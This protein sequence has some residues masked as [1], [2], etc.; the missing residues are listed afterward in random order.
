[1]TPLRA[2][3][4][5]SRAVGVCGALLWAVAFQTPLAV[6]A[7]PQPGDVFREYTWLPEMAGSDSDF[8][9][10]GGRLGY[11][12]NGDHIPPNQHRDG[13]LPFGHALD[14]ERATRAEVVLER[15]ESHD[16]THGLTLYINGHD[17]LP[18][19]DPAG[20]PGVAA[21]YMYHDYPVVDVPLEQLYGGQGNT[22]KLAVDSTQRWG[23]P[24]NLFYGV[25]LRVYYAPA[26]ASLSA[27]IAGLSSGAVVEAQ[28]ALSLET[29]APQDVAHVDY[30][31]LFDDV[32][33][34]GDGVY[35]QWQY[36]YHKG[37]LR[38]HIGTA[39]GAPF[40]VTWET[41]W[42]PDQPAP[43]QVA[44]RVTDR[45]GL[46]HLT[47]AVERL[48]LDRNYHVE[49]AR[50]YRQPANWS[51]REDS[52][53]A[54]AALHGDPS[55]AEAVQIVWRSWSPC[56]ARGV[57][58]NGTPVYDRRDEPC[59]DYAEHRLEIDDPDFLRH[60]ENTI[61]T[62]MTPYYDGKMVHGMEVQWPGVMMKVRYRAGARETSEA[63]RIERGTYAARPHFLVHTP[64][65]VYYYD[66]ASGGLSRLIDA[67]GNDWIA[68]WPDPWDT[69]PASAASAYRGVPNLVFGSD[70]GG[71]GHPGHN[72][73]RT[74]RVGDAALRFTSASEQWQ[75]TWHFSVDHARL[76]VER[77]D[78]D[79]AYWFLYEGTPGGVWAPA[80]YY[81]GTDEAGPHTD[82]PDF[83]TGDKRFGTWQW[84]YFGHQDAGR[85]LFV[86]QREP[87]QHADVVGYLGNTLEGTAAPD[88]MV[89]FGF[90]RQDGA[91]PLLT[92]P[93][94]FFLGLTDEAVRDAS[95]HA[96]VKQ[97]IE[98][99][100]ESSTP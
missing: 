23:W 21:S 77:V 41:G 38:N 26:K 15:V 93:H 46:I 43:M 31:G 16:G 69:Y 32:N 19:P 4:R 100:V 65:A 75:W 40:Q 85:A 2:R 27:R 54:Y 68:F 91:L 96:Q 97:Q 17:G 55:Q 58:I 44:A 37:R 22:F 25:T 3:S 99:L 59:Y 66:I 13:H 49:L 11:T 33:W 12:V 62:G 10:V 1:M 94:T 71:A 73:G 57:F 6:H 8:L 48:T 64:R 89:V 28:E 98:R 76:D 45:A 53:V 39:T 36:H 50:P 34:P 42:L 78:P 29:D 95:A 83:F 60:G 86:A 79:H 35:R 24:Q 51:T 7:Q 90:G 67:A 14:L 47:A 92:E 30:V 81:W 9:R 61:A 72:L 18:V 82:A 88:G 63:V 70:D 87:D 20:I 52:L 56:Y 5:F 84:A 74:E 80:R